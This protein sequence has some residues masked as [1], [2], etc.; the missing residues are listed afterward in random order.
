MDYAWQI[1]NNSIQR[2][3]AGVFVWWLLGGENIH[4]SLCVH[5]VIAVMQVQIY[6]TAINENQSVH[7]NTRYASLE[8]SSRMA[9][10]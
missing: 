8:S 2:I 10:R 9:L 6:G 3:Q 7:D 4:S 5:R 1:V